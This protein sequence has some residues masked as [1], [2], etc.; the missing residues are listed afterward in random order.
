MLT[1]E[2]RARI[3]AAVEAAEA[4]TSGEVVC[5]FSQEVSHYPEVALAW[6]AIAALALPSLAIGLGLH[7]L[8]LA[9]Q[10]GLW[11]AG[12]NAT[13]GGQIALALGLYAAA[14]TLLFVVVFLLA[15]IPPVRRALT[16][17]FL[18]R[19]RVDRAARQQFAAISARAEGSETGVLIFVAPTDRQVRILVADALH[20]K[21]DDQAW[22]R[23]VAAIGAAMR[24]GHDPTSGV[25][26]AIG[27]CGE[28]LHAHFPAA[29]DSLNT[30][31]N[32]PL[33][34]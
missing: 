24:G 14:Q 32:G 6:A 11:T 2:D 28:V 7:P 31:Q 10:A 20:S 27:I 23:A 8:G 9:A 5:V 16:P 22:A 33:E 15:E 25:V 34:V 3:A 4:G 21:A 18:K 12:Q 29:G 1:A 19:H 13:F 30:F 17:N 26:E